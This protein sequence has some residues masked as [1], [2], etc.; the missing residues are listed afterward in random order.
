MKKILFWSVLAMMAAVS[1]N[2]ELENNTP[3]APETEPVT[4]IATV[5]GAETKTILGTDRTPMWAGE[6]SITIHNGTNGYL[7]TATA[8]AAG[9]ATAT[10]SYTGDDFTGNKFLAVYPAGT[11]TAD[12]TAK[13]V[14]GITF[15]EK[16]VVVADTYPANAAFAAAYSE[17]NNLQFRN[18]VAVIAFKVA[19][20][21]IT[22]GCLYAKNGGDIT[23]TYDLTFTNLEDD[24]YGYE[25]PV[26][27]A[28]GA[29][30]WA[31]FHNNGVG[32]S[33]E[34]TYYIA[35]APTT[36][37]EG[38][39]ISLNG[40]EVKNTSKAVTF[41]RNVVYNIGTLEMPEPS[42]NWSISGEMNK[43]GD[44][45]MT[46][47]DDWYVAKSI[48]ISTSDGF[49]FRTDKSWTINKGGIGE[50]AVADKEYT[51]SQNGDDIYVAVS[52]IYDVYLSKDASKMKI[53]K[54]DDYPFDFTNYPGE[55]GKVVVYA[56]GTYTHLWM[57]R[58]K[59]ELNYTG[60]TW[61][62]V[63]GTTGLAID[64]KTYTKFTL[65]N[66]TAIGEDVKVILSGG[67]G[68]AQTGNSEIMKGASIMVLGKTGNQACLVASK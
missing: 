36:F 20:A 37:P 66:E 24:E 11:Y 12:V 1:C 45:E 64:G 8:D 53:V 39:G 54:V 59:D 43:W 50:K 31:D 21:D 30:Q 28:T 27:T 41:K 61:P 48:A 46:L 22:Y 58:E 17:D 60:G 57:W 10:F 51:V 15:P 38:F 3:E 35:I 62:G 68:N 25:V 5:D 16:Q 33:T 56:E 32:M 42:E 23:G 29:K 7:F 49:K 40:V 63:E 18:A 13:T 67:E 34:K 55:E 52:A 26:L 47:E 9:E 2:K 65:A 6:E 4:F 14:S 19:D 44:T